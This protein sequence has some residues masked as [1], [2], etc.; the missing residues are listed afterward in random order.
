MSVRLKKLA[1]QVI[2]VTGATSGIGLATTRMAASS[3]ARIVVVARDPQAV[4]KLVDEITSGGG[5]A[6]GLP[7]DMGNEA[8]VKNLAERTIAHFGG[9]DT[10]VNNA[11]TSVFGHMLDVA[12]ED[13]RR[14]FDTNFWGVVYGSLAA[15]RHF[16]TRTGDYGGALINVGS[17]LSDRAIP[18]QGMYCASKHAVKGFTEALRMELAMEDVPAS[19]SLVKPSSI[20]TPLPQHARNYMTDEPT[21]PPP[22]Y[23]P[24]AVARAILHCAERPTRDVTVGAGG[25]SIVA[26]GAIS[27][28]GTDRLMEC[29]FEGLMK[30]GQPPQNPDGSLNAPRGP[31]LEERGDYRGPVLGRSWYTA[32]MLRPV[33]ASLLV[34]GAGVAVGALIGSLS[35]GTSSRRG[36]RE[37]RKPHQAT[38]PVL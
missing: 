18:I 35:G 33:T 16:R 24:D 21:L 27:P 38:A 9:F 22:L 19:V 4:Q 6:I 37:P 32:A 34:V 15:A 26:M 30:K 14:L 2:V 28:R 8:E 3:G 23:T 11:G 17:I 13:H 20:D 29:T 25:K 10:W 5:E 12:T 1:D 31:E 7:S 36:H